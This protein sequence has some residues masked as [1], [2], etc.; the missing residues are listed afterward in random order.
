VLCATAAAL[1]WAAASGA[2]YF[3]RTREAERLAAARFSFDLQPPTR[4]QSIL[5]FSP[6]PD[7]ETLAC[8]GLIEQ[9]RRNGARVRV[10]FLTSGDA[11]THA[12][13]RQF[14]TLR[15]TPADF[16]R[17]GELRMREARN[18]C[19]IFGVPSDDVRFLG[20]PDGGLSDLWRVN[21]SS[22]VPRKSRFT[23]VYSVPYREC[24]TYGAPYCGEELLEAIK[25]EIG[26][27]QP[28]DVF[29]PHP[30]D[31]H[32]DHSTTSAFVTAALNSLSE[33]DALPA[34]GCARHYYIVHRGDWPQ[35]Q[36]FH[37]DQRLAPPAELLGLDTYWSGV[38]LTPSQIDCK[39]RALDAYR[40]QR[41]VIGRFM[42]SF[43]R[44]SEIFGTIHPLTFGLAHPSR[45]GDDVTAMR[46]LPEPVGDNLIREW[47]PEAD[48]RGMDLSAVDGR[49]TIQVRTENPPGP[50]GRVRVHVRWFGAPESGASGAM[51]LRTQNWLGND[52]GRLL[53]RDDRGF[54]ARI[55]LHRFRG[56]EALFVEADTSIAGVTVDRTG[57]R[58]VLLKDESL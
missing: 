55:P 14:R 35:P 23:Q 7:D 46:L 8:G 11:F 41:S 21:W 19:G 1:V 16:L 15:T 50:E 10:V 24:D 37:P 48:I 26:D 6:H 34:N 28:T 52:S 53:T 32:R 30:A 40:S 39:A 57:P 56:A 3:W 27:F 31:D 58:F 22:G 44:S 5:I 33:E 38:V 47:R 29:A 36:G 49:L 18:A 17:L 42:S 13:E 2:A 12:A 20:F 25:E 45:V 54:T 43:V 9:A 4:G 51:E